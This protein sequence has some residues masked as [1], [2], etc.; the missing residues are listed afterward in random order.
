MLQKKRKRV[1]RP[2]SE[3]ADHGNMMGEE[4]GSNLRKTYA[5][6]SV[7]PLTRKSETA[8]CFCGASDVIKGLQRKRRLIIA[9][10]VKVVVKGSKWRTMTTKQVRSLLHTNSG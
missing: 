8:Y 6:V 9:V 4:R 1:A 10:Y 5:I 2:A 3:T 7:D